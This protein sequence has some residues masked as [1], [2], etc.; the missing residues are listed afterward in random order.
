MIEMVPVTNA[1]TPLTVAGDASLERSAV[2]RSMPPVDSSSAMSVLTP[3][4]IRMTPQGTRLIAVVSSAT[5]NRD[6]HDDRRERAQARDSI[7]RR[8][9]R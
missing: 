4:T 3:L 6:E 9:R 5:P 1:M 2:N 8:E 7:S